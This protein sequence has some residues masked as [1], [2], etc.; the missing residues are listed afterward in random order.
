M[1]FKEIGERLGISDTRVEQI[2]NAALRKMR[3]A[4]RRD[5]VLQRALAAEMDFPPLCKSLESERTGR[6]YMAGGRR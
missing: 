3:N 4:L 1:S 5:L 6:H 2:H